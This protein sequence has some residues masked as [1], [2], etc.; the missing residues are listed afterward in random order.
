[1]IAA[2]GPAIQCGKELFKE[3]L[4]N[5]QASNWSRMGSSNSTCE[6]RGSGR[7]WHLRVRQ[8]L[9]LCQQQLCAQRKTRTAR[10]A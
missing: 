7:A 10:T 8:V 2:Q 9:H 3:A 6:V 5:L 1:M 4:C